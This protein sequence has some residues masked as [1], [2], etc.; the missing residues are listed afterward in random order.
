MKTKKQQGSAHLIIIVV[1]LVALLAALGIVFYQN[2]VQKDKVASDKATAAKQIDSEQSKPVATKQ[3]VSKKHGVTFAY[4]STWSA[5][6]TIAEDDAMSYSSTT[7][8]KDAEGTVVAVLATGTERGGACDPESPQFQITTLNSHAL[9]N[10]G[11]ATA[12]YSS[13][14]VREAD[15]TYRV[16]YGIT[17]SPL[18]NGTSSVQCPSQSV[19]FSYGINIDAPLQNISFGKWSASDGTSY[20]TLADA[21]AYLQSPTFKQV[22]QMIESLKIQTS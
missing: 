1:L 14:I 3:F 7:Q 16:A 4:P 15:G 10:V 5:T 13:T 12:S 19:D 22:E 18:P 21:E 6:E 17:S 11:I 20:R 9:E 8:V 2:F